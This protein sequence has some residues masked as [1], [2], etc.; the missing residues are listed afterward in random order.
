[1]TTKY[2]QLNKHEHFTIE[3]LLSVANAIIERLRSQ[4]VQIKTLTIDNGVE[5]GVM[6]RHKYHH[7]NDYSYV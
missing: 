7:N 6:Q 3:L 4:N 1:M 5:F 2:K